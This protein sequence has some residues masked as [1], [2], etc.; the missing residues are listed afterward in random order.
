MALIYETKN[1]IVEAPE[2][3]HVDRNDS[4]HI[5]IL[6]KVRIPDRQHLSPKLAVKFMRLTVVVG[7]AM[8]KVMN[9]HGVDIGRINYQDMGNWSVFSP[10]GSYFHIH[11]YGRAKSAKFQKYGHCLNLPR[12]TEHPEFYAD[13][14]PLS[15][16]D[17]KGIKSEIEKL[18]SEEKY[19]DKEW[20]LS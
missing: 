15:K 5:K 12:R 14:K 18:F 2:K 20:G 9:A 10:Q 4:G 13:F 16:E 11:L 6:P 17:I 1:F 8:S 19:S 3:P 7:D